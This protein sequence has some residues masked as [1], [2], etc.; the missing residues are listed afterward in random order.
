MDPGQRRLAERR[1]VHALQR[2]HRREPLVPDFRVDAL[3]DAARTVP[4]AAAGHRGSVELTL[5]DAELR[6]VVDV[7]VDAGRLQRRGH[8]VRL[9]D[10]QPRL[11]GEMRARV[12]QL[13]DGLREAGAEPPRVEGI[14]ARL[15]ITAPVL[16]Q[17]RRSGE[18]VSVAGGIDYP[19][20]VW[21][22]IDARLGELG[23]ALSVGRVR[24]ELRTSR[25]HAEAILA[26]RRVRP[27]SRG[28][29]PRRKRD[30]RGVR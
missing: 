26:H 21:A 9:R 27:R 25:R 17:L 28:A 6:S 12:E 4:R 30:R 16:D 19:A 15:G 24:D 23:G 3:V 22:A 2:L 20:D 7:L 8:R 14:A 10:H 29:E 5:S 13:L 11:D 1:L 18:L